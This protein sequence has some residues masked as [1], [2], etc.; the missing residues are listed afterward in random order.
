[1][2]SIQQ[3]LSF[4]Y[5]FEFRPYTQLSTI[6]LMAIFFAIMLLAGIIAK[7][8]AKFGK[9]LEKYQI[10]LLGK[11]FTLLSLMGAWGLFITLT[12]YEYVNFFGARFWQ[13]IWLIVFIIGLYPIIK[14]QIKVVP[15]A[16]KQ[17]AERQ[18]Y[19]KY[20]PKKK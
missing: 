2:F 5:W 18:A 1:M 10:K 3:L 17:S 8:W 19:T 12:R 13:I 4:N 14:Y 20:L 9:K 16:K 6:K 7:L 11:Y 15:E